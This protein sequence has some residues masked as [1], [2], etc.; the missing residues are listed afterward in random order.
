MV[1]I[2]R[3]CAALKTNDLLVSLFD[4]VESIP[5][6]VERCCQVDVLDGQ[7]LPQNVCRDCLDMLNKSFAFAEK[8][9]MAQNTLH[10]AFPSPN[11]A[12]PPTA[13]PVVENIPQVDCVANWDERKVSIRCCRLQLVKK[14]ITNK[15][16]LSRRHR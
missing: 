15:N 13:Q 16:H 3:L 4:A 9:A 11:I 14:L 5:T 12:S 10:T 2:C 6:K 1:G 7:E 8:V